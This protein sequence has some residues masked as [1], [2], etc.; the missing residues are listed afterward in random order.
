MHSC[1]SIER[2]FH[3]YLAGFINRLISMRE[4]IQTLKE[5]QKIITRVRYWIDE[6]VVGLNLCPFANSVMQQ[7][8]VHYVVS[9]SEMV[10]SL[11][12]E[13]YQQCQHLIATPDIETTL[14]IIPHQLQKFTDFN[15][16]LDQVDAL[17]EAF[18]WIGVFQIASFH[19][20]YQFSGT[21]PGDRENW[22]NRSPFPILHI[23]RESS[24]TRAVSRYKDPEKIPETNIRT[25]KAVDSMEFD[26]VFNPPHLPK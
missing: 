6:A 9:K 22:S 15:Q 20:G 19:P 13:L 8:K 26:R 1:E 25:L 10:E 5:D 17:I 24:V 18:S 4:V 16:I 14:L 11:M 2:I 3:V 12:L 7:D 23:L 21:S